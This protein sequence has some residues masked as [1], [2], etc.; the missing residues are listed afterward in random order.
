MTCRPGHPPRHPDFEPG[1]VVAVK[2]GAWSPRR[3][4]P[5][6]TELVEQVT[7]SV[8]WLRPC[9]SSAVWAWAR[10]EA[11]V[12]LVT[13]F[14]MD[15]G[16]DL[17]ADDATRRA[18]DLLTRLEARAESLRS[19][20]GFDPL[21]RA[22]LGRDVAASKVD[23]ASIIAKGAEIASRRLEAIDATEVPADENE[24]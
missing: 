7:S 17:G 16:G 8:D 22:R 14:L 1:N 24:P 18:S 13:E 10:C 15:H 23:L 12:Q 4:D 6:A 9:D 3:V 21:S 20:L 5:L 2:H 11:R 19:K